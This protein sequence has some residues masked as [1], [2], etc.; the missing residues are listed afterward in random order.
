MKLLSKIKPF[1]AMVGLLLY[2][3]V[4]F[5]NFQQNVICFE[6]DGKIE[7]EELVFG[8]CI[9]AFA[10]SEKSSLSKSGE[11]LTHRKHCV[12]IPILFG[13]QSPHVFSKVTL[14]WFSEAVSCT[15]FVQCPSLLKILTVTQ[16]SNPPPFIP[17]VQNL[18]PSYV[19]TIRL[20]S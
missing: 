20:L 3:I 13:K 9:D 2:L 11:A 17:F 5:G 8:H 15:E 1:M 4:S 10:M 16:L 19:E 6:P 12:D 14:K 18:V 7:L